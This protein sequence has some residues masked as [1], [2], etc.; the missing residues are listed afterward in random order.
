MAR[1]SNGIALLVALGASAAAA[2]DRAVT[3]HA[4]QLLDGRG[5]SAR[6]VTITVTGSK[7][8]AVTKGATTPADYE[9]GKLT[10]LPGLIDSHTHITAH[11]NKD[12]RASTQGESGETKGVKWAENVELTLMS[13]YT[14]IQSMGSDDDYV[15]RD[16][17]ASGRLIGPRLLTSG[18]PI[19]DPKMTPDAIR[20]YVRQSKANGADFIKLFA[21]ESIRD[22]G[23]PTLSDAQVQAACGEAKAQGMRIWVHAH[24]ASAVTQAVNA[25]C[26]AITHGFLT[27][28]KELDL[29][30]RKGTWFEPNVGVVLQNY[31]AH[32][33]NYEGIGNYTSA[34]FESMI[35]YAGKAPAFWERVH[36]TK[37]L[38]VISGGDTNAG[39]E[40]NNV[41]EVIFRVQN[42]Q[43]AMDAIVDSTSTDAEAL[44]LGQTVG[45][46]V[47]GME[48]DIIAVDGDPLKDITALRKVTFVMKGGKVY[49]NV[50]K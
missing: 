8:T 28:Q 47:P 40:G 6:D 37:G 45:S 12:G 16:A 30:A 35:E 26:Y 42:G 24:A 50:A 48:A 11:F 20:A 23:G 31:I 33:K 5:G 10:V 27:T 49:K 21:S 9:F 13:G 1:L 19:N 4:G 34:A 29:M 3:I 7:I 44:G 18:R 43:P 38:K 14:T 46:I 2:Q 15:L 39:A 32:R 36:K 25:S 22:G 41:Q 17:I